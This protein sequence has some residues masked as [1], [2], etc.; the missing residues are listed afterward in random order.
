MDNAEL[1]A[2]A[3]VG[4][5][6]QGWVAPHT[7]ET[8]SKTRSTELQ[9]SVRDW[10]EG[11]LL[12]TSAQLNSLSVRSCLRHRRHSGPIDKPLLVKMIGWLLVALVK[13]GEKGWAEPSEW[14]CSAFASLAILLGQVHQLSPLR[15]GNCRSSQVEVS[16]EMRVQIC[17]CYHVTRM[18]T[19]S[20]GKETRA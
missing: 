8:Q 6:Q 17:S 2:Q 11:F 13:V 18:V 12:H 5:S 4:N 1:T 10:S 15:A 19:P 16:S 3:D 9:G 7:L 20:M 14:F